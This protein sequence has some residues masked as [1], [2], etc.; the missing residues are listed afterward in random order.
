MIY[1]EDA[2]LTVGAHGLD[3]IRKFN[4]VN[5][6]ENGNENARRYPLEMPI[7]FSYKSPLPDHMV[8]FKAGVIVMLLCNLDPKKGPVIGTGYKCRKNDEQYLSLQIATS[9]REDTRL[10]LH[11]IRRE[12]GENSF[13]VPGL[14]CLQF[15]IYMWFA[16]GECKIQEQLFGEKLEI[17]ICEDFFSMISCPWRCWEPCTSFRELRT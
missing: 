17:D 16:I 5:T 11:K 7:A 2:Q 3:E 13:I 8:I 6:G 15:P 9:M 12:P 1:L 10:T 14:F 4:S